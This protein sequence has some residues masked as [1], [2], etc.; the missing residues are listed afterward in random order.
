MHNKSKH[1]LNFR[2]YDK[3]MAKSSEKGCVCVCVIF[4]VK[5]KPGERLLFAG[6][7]NSNKQQLMGV[8]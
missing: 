3:H 1:G 7:G 6:R 4:Q 2:V 8:R 5:T